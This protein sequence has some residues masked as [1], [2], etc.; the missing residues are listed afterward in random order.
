MDAKSKAPLPTCWI[1]SHNKCKWF[2]MLF[3]IT[4][5]DAKVKKNEDTLHTPFLLCFTMNMLGLQQDVPCWHFPLD[6][7]LGDVIRKRNNHG[8]S[9]FWTT[10]ITFITGGNTR[11]WL[12]T[13]KCCPLP[14]NTSNY[15][16]YHETRLIV[17]MKHGI[18]EKH[19]KYHQQTEAM[20][21]FAMKKDFI[22][23]F[24]WSS[25]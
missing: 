17:C 19:N 9:S 8:K 24:I 2:S 1:S 20:M 11:V 18:S 15:V 5:E 14:K 12:H 7:L 13:L 23:S 4:S 22:E 3:F 21:I 6:F 10:P 25:L 16:F